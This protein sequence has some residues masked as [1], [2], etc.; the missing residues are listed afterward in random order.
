MARQPQDTVAIP[1]GMKGI[2][3]EFDILIRNG[4]IIDGSGSAPR[5]A[6]LAIS[7]DRIEVVDPLPDATAATEIDATGRVVAPGFIDVHVHSE[8]ALLGG[9]HRYGSVLQGVTTHLLGPD[10][11]GWAPLSPEMATQ[12]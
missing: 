4:Q 9:P 6:D 10:G 2:G 12:M 3:V 1:D 11:F 5:A 7:G 8:V